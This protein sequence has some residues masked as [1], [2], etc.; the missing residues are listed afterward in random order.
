MS[1]ERYGRCGPV[2]FLDVAPELV[3]EILSPEDL[4]GETQTKVREYL[5]IGVDRVWIVDPR[6]RQVQ[7]YRS[8][9]QVETLE[10]GDTLR[11]GEILPGFSLSLSDL[12]RG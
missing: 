9:E 1:H 7:I 5:A 6:R 2:T 12:F 8:P 10:I 11:D 3:V 4:P